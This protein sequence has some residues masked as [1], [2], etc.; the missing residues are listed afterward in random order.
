ML[1]VLIDMCTQQENAESIWSGLFEDSSMQR[2]KVR[3]LCVL[4]FN[5][6]ACQMKRLIECF[7]LWTWQHS[8]ARKE[9]VRTNEQDS[10]SVR[11]RFPII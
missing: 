1:Y 8:L 11:S 3:F 10:Q 7:F 6:S 9:L 2:S 5:F 4:R